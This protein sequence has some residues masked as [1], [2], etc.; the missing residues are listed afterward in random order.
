[1]LLAISCSGPRDRNRFGDVACSFEEPGADFRPAPFWVWNARMDSSDIDRMLPDFARQG[2]GGVFVHPRPGMETEYL[3]EDWFNLWSY[4]LEKGREL[5]LKL[6][7]YDENSYPSGFAGGHV[8]ARWP[9]TWSSCAWAWRAARRWPRWSRS[10]TR[11]GTW[12]T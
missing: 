1:M 10:W 7:I 5:G 12:A 2:F 3:S 6:W 11:C 9:D 4:S 8:A